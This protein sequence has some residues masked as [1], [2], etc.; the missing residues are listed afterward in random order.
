MLVSYLLAV[1]IA[2]VYFF[3]IGQ[4]SM[5]DRLL[6]TAVALIIE[7]VLVAVPFSKSRRQQ[8]PPEMSAPRR[9]VNRATAPGAKPE[10]YT[11]TTKRLSSGSLDYY[12]RPPQVPEMHRRQTTSRIHRHPVDIRMGTRDN[13][14]CSKPQPLPEE[15]YDIPFEP[16][17][18]FEELD[19]LMEQC[20]NPAAWLKI[21]G[22]ARLL[23][24][25]AQNNGTRQLIDI[26]LHIDET[27]AEIAQLEATRNQSLSVAELL[28]LLEEHFQ[29][30]K[31]IQ[32]KARNYGR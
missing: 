20:S 10:A 27:M 4:F 1:I 19:E 13:S 7:M 26:W 17:E 18:V 6:I 23:A 29:L 28:E 31:G 14:T 32:K 2:I 8:L 21:K 11:G 15:P 22:T 3:V 9:P 24:Y 16:F 12:N 5:A 25:K 30:L